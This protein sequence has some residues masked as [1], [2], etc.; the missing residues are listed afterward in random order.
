MSTE[1]VFASE[2]VVE[3]LV[4]EGKKFKDVDALV[5][6]KVEADAYI[7]N[8]KREINELKNTVSN[9]SAV[10]TEVERL[11]EEMKSLR[12]AG[13]QSRDGTRPALSESQV[14][15]L[16]ENTISQSETTRIVNQNIREANDRLVQHFGTLDKAQAAVKAK[17]MELGVSLDFLRDTAGKSP[18][19]FMNT[20]GIFNSTGA[21]QDIV[22]D[23][24][25]NTGVQLDTSGQL[26]P[27]TKA[28]FDKIRN[29]NKSE[30][31]SSD[32]QQQIWK[33]VKAGTYII[34][35]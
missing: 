16:V 21:T 14:K 2:A 26:K 10:Q 23:N 30:Y 25:V 32:V 28:Y 9:T 13:S 3:D 27:G 1:S 29:E 8:L 34:P 31:F 15:A 20:L 24:V 33:A 18:L 7:E 35:G 11:K 19:A 6:G 17:A 5:K 22:I 12:E 4:G